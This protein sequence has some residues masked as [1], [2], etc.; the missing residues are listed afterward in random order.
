MEDAESKSGRT[1]ECGNRGDL[2]QVLSS[3]TACVQRRKKNSTTKTK[4]SNVKIGKG[5]E[6]IFLQRRCTNGQRAHE[7]MPDITNH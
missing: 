3:K 5:L 7:K 2:G 4:Q 1:E 6:Q